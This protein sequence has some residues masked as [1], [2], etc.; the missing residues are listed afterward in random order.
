MNSPIKQPELCN[1]NAP[2]SMWSLVACCMTKA[3]FKLVNLVGTL[4]RPFKVL[5]PAQRTLTVGGSITVRLEQDDRCDVS[6]WTY[7]FH[8]G[9]GSSFSGLR[10]LLDFAFHEGSRFKFKHMNFNFER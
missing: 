2:F 9:F 1:Y 6:V 7:I 10:S 4:L 8:W 5:Y 3:A